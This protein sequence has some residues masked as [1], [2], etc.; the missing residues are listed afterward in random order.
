MPILPSPKLND[1]QHVNA[2]LTASRTVGE[3]ARIPGFGGWRGELGLLIQLWTLNAMTW[4]PR[5]M[6]PLAER[7]R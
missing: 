5:D 3:L 1:G 4:L 2:F 6:E 7:P